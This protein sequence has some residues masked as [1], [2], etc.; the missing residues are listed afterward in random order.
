M[1]LHNVQGVGC[2]KEL[3]ERNENMPKLSNDQWVNHNVKLRKEGKLSPHQWSQFKE[4]ARGLPRVIA[5]PYV[6]VIPGPV[7]KRSL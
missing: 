4:Q 1:A 7:Q 3:M 2:R 6:S 5:T